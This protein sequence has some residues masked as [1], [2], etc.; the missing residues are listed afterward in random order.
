M[1]AKTGSNSDHIESVDGW[2]LEGK[3]L[4]STIYGNEA[5][6]N[7]VVKIP[8]PGRIRQKNITNNMLRLPEN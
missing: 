6:I 5:T 8:T 3:V 2:Y 7:V 1:L 4:D